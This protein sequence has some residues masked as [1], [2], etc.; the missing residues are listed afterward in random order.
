MDYNIEGNKVSFVA[1]FRVLRLMD[2]RNKVLNTEYKTL[3]K[4]TRRGGQA[5]LFFSINL[6]RKK[7]PYY[8]YLISLFTIQYLV[9]PKLVY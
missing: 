9:L 8:I 4:F 1:D 7:S 5:S 2:F 6:S 3:P